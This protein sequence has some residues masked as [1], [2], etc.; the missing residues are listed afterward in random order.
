MRGM[1]L[2]CTC[3]LSTSLG[4]STPVAETRTSAAKA[5]KRGGK[6]VK[7][8]DGLVKQKVDMQGVLTQRVWPSTPAVST[9]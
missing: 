8:V 3:A 9:R 7:T 4:C 5:V 2:T 1:T 6:V